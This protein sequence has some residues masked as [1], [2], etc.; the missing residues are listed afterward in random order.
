MALLD[1]KQLNPRLT[2]SFI[3]SG[4]TQT[5]IGA[6]DF[7]GSITVTGNVSGSVT[8]TGSFS[9]VDTTLVRSLG[10]TDTYID[11]SPVADRMI[12][13][14]GNEQMLK[15]SEGATDEVVVGDGGDIDFRVASIGGA[16]L[17][18]QGSDMYVGMGGNITPTQA[19]TI[20]GNI[21]ASGALMGITHI[22]ASGNI[23]GSTSTTGSFGRVDVVK[24][25]YASGRIYEAGSS[26]IDQATAMAIVFGG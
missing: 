20:T 19:L 25:I 4:S 1:S 3:L 13:Y 18:V 5:F 10:D 16:G 11:L 24:D 8:S 22:S 23:S 15:L 26:V 9:Q 7:Q 12:F 6:S 21:S 2:G 17:F 14:A